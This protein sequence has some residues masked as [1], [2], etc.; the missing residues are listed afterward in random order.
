MPHG[1]LKRTVDGDSWRRN[2]LASVYVVGVF[3]LANSYV[4]EL[5]FSH[6]ELGAALAMMGALLLGCPL[7][8]HAVRDLMTGALEMNELAALSFT[9]SFCTGQY[10]AAAFI[11]LFMIAAQ[12]IELRSQLGARKRLEALM[13]L[14]PEKARV[15]DG[16]GTIACNAAD[17]RHGDI[18]E[19][20]PGDRIPGD[21]VVVE[22]SSAV[23][24][25]TLTG[26]SVP[27][28]KAVGAEVFGGTLNCTGRLLLRISAAASQST[29]AKIREMIAQAECSRTAAMRLVNSY[30]VWYTP[31][32][33]LLAAIV[34]FFTHD[35]NRA[36]AMV[37]IACPCTVLLSGP[38]ALVAALST[39]ARLGV[40]V[41]DVA[42]LETAARVDTVVFDK[43]GT[44]THGR[45]TVTAVRPLD[46][47][48]VDDLLR[49]AGSVGRYSHHPAAAAVAAECTARGLAYGTVDQLS[50]CAGSGVR[51]C[52]NGK[53]VT[54]GRREWV[55]A[56]CASGAIPDQNAAHGTTV[57]VA[58]DMYHAGVVELADTLKPDAVEIV[59]QLRDGFAPNIV[60]MTG[61]RHAAAEKIA[62]LLGCTFEAEVLPQ[63]KMQRVEDARARG[64][65]VAV[66]GDGV[67]DA[68]ALA[69]GDVGIAMGARG[70]DVAIHSASFVLMND[71]LDRLPF[72]FR[73]SRRVMTVMRQNLAFSSLFI[74]VT[75]AL[76]AA[77]AIPPVL[78]AVLHASSTIAVIAN[79]ARLLREGEALA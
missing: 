19:V 26:E 58:V 8:Y 76:S 31:L 67:N 11:A 65:V 47:Y 60:M 21:G 71:K 53:T 15:V 27:V 28:E 22:G 35:I 70:S 41:R 79:S 1:F 6:H 25:A 75:L 62:K 38:T 14:A 20:L 46:G 36:I 3:F 54:M 44:L 2:A 42:A 17:L 40:I 43:T 55:T 74:V 33:L 16:N 49:L 30:A 68:P 13:N 61:D 50:E 48:P 56:H 10:R 4:A 24:E 5:L 9:A 52:V 12:L 39:A 18:V 73:L 57:D 51:G 66:V 78:A 59:N 37:I 34:L 7:V 63:Q 23:D 32:I 69:A 29:L 45:F 72:L 64:H 77:G